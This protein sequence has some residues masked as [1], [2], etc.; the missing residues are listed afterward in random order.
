MW[1]PQELTESQIQRCLNTISSNTFYMLVGDALSSG[2]NLSAIRMADGERM[3]MDICNSDDSEYIQPSHEFNEEW[4]KQFGVS[5]IP[6]TVLK[7]RLVKAATEADYF[8]PS[9]SGIV[10]PLY[11]VDDFRVQDKYVDNFFPNAWDEEMKIDLFKKAG[12]VLVIHANT[13][14]ADAIQI[15]ARFSLGVK[16][17]YLKLTNWS[18][19][20]GVIE[21]AKNIDAP[22]TLFSAGPASKYI[23]NEIAHGGNIP[24]VAL[25]IGQADS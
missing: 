18:E 19:A 13:G 2:K 12:H 6:R 23:G 7:D 14:L 5:N 15:R 24:K 22:L 9:L 20:E 3:L 1:E 4:L 21:K 16:V 25:D 10:M 11:N 17:T 8:S